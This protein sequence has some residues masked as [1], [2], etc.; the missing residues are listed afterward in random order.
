MKHAQH[1]FIVIAAAA[2]LAAC[3]LCAD[4]LTGR[5]EGAGTQ[6]P[7]GYE[8]AMLSNGRICLTVDYTGAVP[9]PLPPRERSKYGKLTPGF[10]VEGR[11]MGPPRWTLYGFG[12]FLPHLAVR[13]K[14]V[15]APDAWSQTLDVHAARSVAT[16]VFGDVTRVVETFVAEGEE[17][18]AVRQRLTAARPMTVSVGLDYLPPEDPRIIGEERRAGGVRFFDFRAFGCS[19][20]TNCVAVAGGAPQTVA[21]EP[22]RW[23]TR[24]AFV[25]VGEAHAAC[26]AR[27][28]ACVKDGYDALFA[29]HAAAWAAYYAASRVEIPDAR[30]RRLRDV[31]EY[32]LKCNLT[33]WTLP[34]GIFP[35]HWSGRSFAF[36]E[37]YGVQG[38]LSAGHL[39][40]ARRTVAFRL[41][42]LAWAKA[43]VGHAHTKQHFGYGARWVWEGMEDLPVDG[44]PGGFWRDHIFHMAAIARS[45][46]L[47]YLADGDEAFLRETAYPV[48]QACAR[49]YRTESVYEE[50]DGGCFIGKC[51]DLE[52]LGPARERAFMTTVGVIATFRAC[53]EAARTLG[54]DAAEAADWRRVADKLVAS[55]P[56]AD[57]RYV[58]YPGSEDVS[59]GTLA[60][61]FPFQVFSRDNTFQVNAA[62]HFLEQGVRGGN[63]YPTGKRICPWYAATMCAA[64]TALEERERPTRLLAACWPSAG[65]WGEFWEINE[66]GLV[67]FRPW[68][69]TA[70]GNYLYALNRVLLSVEGDELRIAPGVPPAWKDYAFRLPAERGVWAACVVRGGALADLTLE[71]ARPAAGRTVRVVLPE[72]LAGGR[73]TVMAKLDRA[74]VR[75]AAPPLR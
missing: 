74:R 72:T 34:V 13:G 73:R 51:T 21:L 12:R 63:M 15:G 58:P 6:T 16:N 27:A 60:G 1:A 68:F 52:R 40:E 56:V 5:V 2:G 55:L 17:V 44:S 53:A 22:G 20:D 59:M 61:F 62:R 37:M 23:E 26:A 4:P 57:G 3:R 67:N 19:L 46:W 36:D 45:A 65:V 70:A 41:R 71:V 66:E 32:Q 49:F 54:C 24:D 50:A 11:R 42:T 38:L 75:V 39:A 10:F 31:A 25:L 33:K 18:V 64:A 30:L 8:P 14:A 28:A 7:R 47:C 29:R 9:P 69:M 35:S 43:R 48:M